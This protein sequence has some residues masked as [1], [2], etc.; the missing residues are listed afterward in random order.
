MQQQQQQLTPTCGFCNQIGH[1]TSNCWTP[2]ESSIQT[3]EWTSIIDNRINDILSYQ[4]ELV[5]LKLINEGGVHT[6]CSLQS[7]T[8]ESLLPIHQEYCACRERRRKQVNSE[9]N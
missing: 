3:K 7:L 9:L 8:L 1:D 2:S 4:R 6:S 5:E